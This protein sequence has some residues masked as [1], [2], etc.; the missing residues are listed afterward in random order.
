MVQS[1]LFPQSRIEHGAARIADPDTAKTAAASV[2][3][4]DLEE[5]VLKALRK[6][7]LAGMTSHELAVYL[8]I[9]LVSISP[10]LRPLV[11]KGLVVDSGE[12]RQGDSHRKSIVWK[13]V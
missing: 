11:N 13:A 2:R 6:Y 10:R 9:E 5:R 12:R 4:A 3:V 1:E 7:P 8:N